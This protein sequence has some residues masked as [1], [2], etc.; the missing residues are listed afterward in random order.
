MKTLYIL[1]S[2]N[3]DG[4][5]S[6]HFTFDSELIETMRNMYRKDTL[7][8]KW[9]DGDGFQYTTLSLPDECT[10]ESLGITMLDRTGI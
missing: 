6:T 1:I 7:D 10:A 5:Y 2:S 4:S 8:C 9:I 3:G